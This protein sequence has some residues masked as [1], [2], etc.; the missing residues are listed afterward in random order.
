MDKWIVMK[1]WSV[2][3]ICISKFCVSVLIFSVKKQ[4]RWN[5]YCFC[6][7]STLPIL[8]SFAEFISTKYCWIKPAN[9]LKWVENICH[10]I[11]EFSLGV[12]AIRLRLLNIKTIKNL[13]EF[14]QLKFFLQNLKISL[15]SID[16][17]WIKNSAFLEGLV[18][19]TYAD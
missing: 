8:N 15:T 9:A 12:A 19:I 11:V 1:N 6:V 14:L 2:I 7:Q 16:Q 10:L 5:S 4:N 17:S 13:F 18:F 3:Q